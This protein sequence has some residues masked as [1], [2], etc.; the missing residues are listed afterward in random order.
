MER[1][2]PT[3]K[4]SIIHIENDKDTKKTYELNGKADV[5]REPFITENEILEIK[6]WDSKERPMVISDGHKKKL[7]ENL[8][9]RITSY[10]LNIKAQIKDD[11]ERKVRA[12]KEEYL[13]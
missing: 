12:Q 11:I 13:K 7:S 6:V 1:K 4:A 5:D 3:I 9:R 8:N 2:N 10:A